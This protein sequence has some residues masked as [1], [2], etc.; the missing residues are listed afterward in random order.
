MI[1]VLNVFFDQPVYLT[2][3]DD[4]DVVKTFAPH[5]AS[6]PFTDRV[7]FGGL[8]R[9]AEYIYHRLQYQM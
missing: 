1:E 5:T 2:P 6:E 3:T 7:G 8:D 9:C 4:Q